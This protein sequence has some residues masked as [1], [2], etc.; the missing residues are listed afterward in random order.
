MFLTEPGHGIVEA[1]FLFPKYW[2]GPPFSGNEYMVDWICMSMNKLASKKAPILSV[3]RHFDISAK[4]S[5]G[6]RLDPRRIS[7]IHGI[8]LS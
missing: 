7:H 4:K 1:R 8:F 5:E 2:Q 3:L 6:E